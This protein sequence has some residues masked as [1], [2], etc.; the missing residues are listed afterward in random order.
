[1]LLGL[2][3]LDRF[4]RLAHARA[5]SAALLG[6][7]LLVSMTLVAALSWFFECVAAWVCVK[8]LGLDVSLADTTVVFCVSTLAG[9]LSFVP[10]GLG[11]AEA[12]VIGLFHRRGGVS[13]PYAAAVTVLIRLAMLWFA[14]VVG[15]VA[16]GIED[17]LERRQA[18]G[19]P[20]A[21][22][23]SMR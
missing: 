2:R 13:K 9:A 11:V 19:S 23:S 22:R 18:G 20:P 21:R 1:M 12:S 10:G 8:G 14:V 16:L 15:L 6:A 7:R 5:A 17:R 4:A 3:L